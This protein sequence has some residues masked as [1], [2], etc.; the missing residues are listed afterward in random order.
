M[1]IGYINQTVSSSHKSDTQRF[2]SKK[3]I[4]SNVLQCIFRLAKR[5]MLYVEMILSKVVARVGKCQDFQLT[6]SHSWSFKIQNNLEER[7]KEKVVTNV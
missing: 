7:L 2:N 5:P 4:P 6:L 1:T 3:S